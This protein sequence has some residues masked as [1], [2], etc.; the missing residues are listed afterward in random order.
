MKAHI[1]PLVS[2]CVYDKRQKVT[3]HMDGNI[4]Y[5]FEYWVG[6]VVH[7][8]LLLLSTPGLHIPLLTEASVA[9]K[10]TLI[11]SWMFLWLLSFSDFLDTAAADKLIIPPQSLSLSLSTIR[12]DDVLT[13]LL[14][15]WKVGRSLIIIDRWFFFV[16]LWLEE[17]SQNVYDNGPSRDQHYKTVLLLFFFIYEPT[18][19]SFIFSFDL[20]KQTSLQVL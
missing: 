13:I 10:K 6:P 2:W 11:R 3:Y 19:A 1:G 17:K 18:A 5:T 4:P 14:E 8:L 16:S 15:S 9:S 12:E 7:L 20:F